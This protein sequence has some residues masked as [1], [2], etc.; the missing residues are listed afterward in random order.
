MSKVK[1]HTGIFISAIAI[2]TSVMAAALPLERTITSASTSIFENSGAPGMVIAVVRGDALIISGYGETKKGNHQKPNADSLLRVGS[3]S[4]VLATDL[5]V[6][7]VDEGKL[8]LSDPLQKYAPFRYKVLDSEGSPSITLLSLATHTSGLPR[9]VGV[10]APNQTI[11]FTWP[12]KTV[13][14]DWLSKQAFVPTGRT[15]LYSNIAYDLLA[16]AISIAGNKPYDQLLLEKV[17]APLR[18]HDTTATPTIEQCNRL[19]IGIGIDPAG[20]C[21][22]TRATA[23]SG[24]MYST[25]ADMGVWMQHLLGIKQSESA[26]QRAI[27]QAIYFQRQT[28]TSIEG[29]DL[30]GKASGL[31]LGWVQL[32]PMENSP[33]ILQK[34]GGG[35]GFMSYMALAPGRQIGIFVAVTKVD[36]DMFAGITRA[37]NE[38]IAMLDVK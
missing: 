6:K 17:T 20:S 24:G 21:A 33:A 29:L 23:G 19:M 11:P 30:A 37:V 15:A 38:L 32:T 16:D 22:D 26:T 9:S 10:K 36:L 18:M 34:T 28:L 4:K 1:L 25:A 8:K 27:A 7:L 14:W 13:R 3:I 2:S 12:D 31:G 35:A 5:I